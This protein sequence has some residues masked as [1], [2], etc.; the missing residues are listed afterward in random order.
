MTLSKAFD[1]LQNAFVPVSGDY[2]LGEV[3]RVLTFL[4]GCTRSRLY[5]NG[6]DELPASQ[7][8][9]IEEVVRRR[10]GDEPIAHI[11]RSAFFYN[12]EFI[13]TSD[14]LIP[15]PDSEV[16]V[17]QVVKHETGNSLRFIDFGT[18]SGCIAAVLADHDPSWRGIAIDC[19]PQALT[20]ARGNCPGSVAL[21]CSDHFS[22]LRPLHAFDIIIS[23]PPY[24]PR[25]DLKNLPKSVRDFEPVIAL[26]GGPDGLDFYR[27]LAENG[28]KLLIN[29]GRIYVEIGYDQGVSVPELFA[30][31]RWTDITVTRDLGNRHRVVRARHPETRQ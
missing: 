28:P 15:R 13:V 30:K 31:R 19:S 24:I 6:S 20:I 25:P 2:A 18:G 3:E 26:D 23:N 12:R 27:Y 11:L 4:L 14:V 5:V 9:R 10:S 16:L 7:A 29:R 22:A 8:S 21:L 1:T 17:E